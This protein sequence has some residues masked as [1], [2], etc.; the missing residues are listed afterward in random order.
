MFYNLQY[1]IT[2][3][4]ASSPR[5]L[6]NYNKYQ[7]FAIQWHGHLCYSLVR[8]LTLLSI[9]CTIAL[10]SHCMVGNSTMQELRILQ[11]SIKQFN[12]GYG[13]VNISHHE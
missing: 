7:Y 9:T 6:M 2:N 8:C 5:I 1:F 10:P 4:H 11:V 3:K 12:S 13:I